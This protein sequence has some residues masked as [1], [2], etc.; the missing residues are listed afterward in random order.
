M[1][2]HQNYTKSMLGGVKVVVRAGIEP[3]TQGFSVFMRQLLVRVENYDLNNINSLQSGS[4]LKIPNLLRF[5]TCH[6]TKITPKKYNYLVVYIDKTCHI[7][8]YRYKKIK[9]I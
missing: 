2:L 3:A 7:T 1:S 4:Q 9:S 6:Y 5:F 8:F